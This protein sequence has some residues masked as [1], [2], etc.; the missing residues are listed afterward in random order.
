MTFCRGREVV[1]PAALRRLSLS[2][3]KSSNLFPCM[4]CSAMTRRCVPSAKVLVIFMAEVKVLV[5]GYTNADVEGESDE[6]RTCATI[7]LVKDKDLVIVVDPGVLKDRSI[8][9]E[10]LKKEGL[11]LEDVNLIVITHSHIDHYRNIGMFPNAKALDFH[12]LWDGDKVDDWEEQLTEDIKII[13]APG[14]HYSSLVLLVKTEEGTVAVVGDI[15]WKEN[16]P[17]DDPYASD[18]EE[19]V[20]SRKKVL[21]LADFIVP[22]H[23]NMFKVK[24]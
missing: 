9:V 23:G 13:K 6:E 12:G 8:L 18:K 15:F 11:T 10:A 16:L 20:K 3:F 17:E 2:A 24:K 14:H 21:E 22:G 5:E 4:S 19:L 1:K 7:S